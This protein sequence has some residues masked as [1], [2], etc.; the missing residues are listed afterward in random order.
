MWDKDEGRE[1]MPPHSQLLSISNE[2]TTRLNV[3]IRR[4]NRYQQYNM[5]SQRMYCGRVWN[6]IQTLDAQSSDWKLYISTPL[7]P[8]ISNDHNKIFDLVGYR[9]LDLFNHRQT[10]YHMSQRDGH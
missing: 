6:L 8:K 1:K 4:T 10:C 9:T 7:T 3:P 2:E 5:P